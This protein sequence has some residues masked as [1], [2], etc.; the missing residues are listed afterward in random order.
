MSRFE[1]ENSKILLSLADDAVTRLGDE[2]ST[3]ERDPW[4]W[5]IDWKVRKKDGRRAF[6]FWKN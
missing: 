2:Q 3:Y 6:D 5:C 1:A 4:M